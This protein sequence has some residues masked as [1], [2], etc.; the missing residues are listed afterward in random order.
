M[1][2]DIGGYGLGIAA[3]IMSEVSDGRLE[4]A[5]LLPFAWRHVPAMELEGRACLPADVYPLVAPGVL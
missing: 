5:P 3:V 2:Y 4:S 1:W